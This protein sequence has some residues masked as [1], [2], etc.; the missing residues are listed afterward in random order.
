M[1]KA[2]SESICQWYRSEDPIHAKMSRIHKH[3][4]E[5]MDFWERDGETN[6]IFINVM[7]KPESSSGWFG[8]ALAQLAIRT[9]IDVCIMLEPEPEQ[10]QNLAEEDLI[11]SRNNPSWAPVGITFMRSKCFT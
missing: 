8:I 9:S 6:K 11:D 4:L 5:L 2:E 1:K 3:C 7:S 10:E